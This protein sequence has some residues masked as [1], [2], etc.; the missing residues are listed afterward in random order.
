[1]KNETVWGKKNLETLFLGE[2]K[3]GMPDT[4]RLNIASSDIHSCS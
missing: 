2:M 1:M 3:S 4:R